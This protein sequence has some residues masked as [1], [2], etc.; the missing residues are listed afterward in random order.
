MKPAL[1]VLA[2]GIGS[3]YG[4]LKQIDPVGPSSE[5]IIDYSIFDAIRAGFGKI[6]FIIRKE[7]EVAFKESIGDKFKKLVQVEYVYQE[8]NAGLPTGF[9]VPKD[10]VKP[11]GTGHAIL[12]AK[13]VVDGPFAVINS[14]DFYGESAFQLI[15]TYLSK[16]KD[17]QYLDYSMV[18]FILKNTLS[19]FGSVSRGVCT[20]DSDDNLIDIVERTDIRKEDNKISYVDGD[21]SY[22]FSGEEIV[23]MNMW[24]FTPSIFEYLED[25]FRDFLEKQGGE[26]KSEFFIPFV[27]DELIKNDVAKVKV[28]KSFDSWFGI[29]YKDDKPHVIENIKR[30]VDQGVYPAKL[31]K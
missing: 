20:C 24:G 12:M 18:G 29:T 5:S 14:D 19:E 6:V 7:I 2:A 26:L 9:S 27:V 13:E 22:L 10:R 21:T 11:W 25:M 23:S 1:V 15:S 8:L 16:A 17:T 31:Y 30:L 3:R 4:G 28:L